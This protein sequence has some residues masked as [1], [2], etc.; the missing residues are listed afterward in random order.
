MVKTLV[1]GAGVMG[2]SVAYRLAQAGAAV[3]VLEA[4]RIGG[5]TSGISFG[6]R[7]MT[8][9]ISPSVCRRA[10]RN[11]A[12]SVSAVVIARAE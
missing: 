9:S 12:R 8:E 3:T 11:T 1:I 6:S 4:T 2:A 10:R 5:G 7:R